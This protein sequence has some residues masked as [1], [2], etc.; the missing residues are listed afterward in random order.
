M[1]RHFNTREKAEHAPP[2]D[3]SL[4]PGG[5]HKEEHK[6]LMPRVMAKLQEIGKYIIATPQG[7]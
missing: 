3:M 7:Q 5:P 4:G 2:C 6:V 1:R